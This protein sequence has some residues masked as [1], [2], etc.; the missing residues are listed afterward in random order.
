MGV[1]ARRVMPHDAHD[2]ALLPGLVASIVHRLAIHRQGLVGDQFD[3]AFRGDRYRLSL[4]ELPSPLLGFMPSNI[5]DLIMSHAVIKLIDLK[6]FGPDTTS[7]GGGT[8]SGGGGITAPDPRTAGGLPVRNSSLV[9][10][11]DV[12]G[13]SGGA[14]R[15]ETPGGGASDTQGNG[16]NSE[17]PDR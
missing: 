6:P 1:A 4:L 11:R 14:G 12:D 2:V 9:P 15:D 3:F 13:T 8:N 7:C 5:E 10:G 16:A 17:E